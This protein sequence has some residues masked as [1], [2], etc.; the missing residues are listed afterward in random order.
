MSYPV[1]AILIFPLDVQA[2]GNYFV[3]WMSINKNL[4]QSVHDN[5][6]RLLNSHTVGSALLNNVIS[7][8]MQAV[9]MPFTIIGINIEPFC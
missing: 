1:S 8:I 4:F 2:V 9:F 7:T 6:R 5:S 3:H